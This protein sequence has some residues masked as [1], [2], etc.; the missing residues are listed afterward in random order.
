MTMRPFNASRVVQDEN[1]RWISD[2][3][4]HHHPEAGQV[5]FG[6]LEVPFDYAVSHRP[7]ARFGPEKI[8]EVL[9]GSTL[10]CADKRVA[11]HSVQ[12]RHFGV[13]DVVHSLSET[14]RNIENQVADIPT[15]YIPICLGGDH[16]ITDPIVR[17]VIGKNRNCKVGL[18]VFDAHFD[19]RDPKKGKEH[20]GH[21][22]NTLEGVIDYHN[23]VQ[24]GI[25]ANIYSETYMKCA[26]DKGVL[27]RTP[28]EIRRAGIQSVL[29]EI[30]QKLDVDKVYISVDI[31]AVD[32]AF[33]PGTSVPNPCGL[34]PHEICDMI[35]EIS[36]HY[37]STGFDVVEVSP[38][39]DGSGAT[40]MIAAQ[41]VFN[42]MAGVV[43]AT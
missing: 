12:L 25:N 10:Y 1:V 31:D 30:F 29:N 34:F 8:L 19:S 7:G 4:S 36:K 5:A 2:H 17:A 28:Y 40:A 24:L 21:W 16:S 33:A 26:E 18:V 13:V 9:N 14:Y 11:L 41:C 22:M 3:W 39:L 15:D 6:F 20:S 38:P 42:F 32:N 43:S 23:V 35:F 37:Q 27:V